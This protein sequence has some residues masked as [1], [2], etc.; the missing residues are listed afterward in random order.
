ML[1]RMD[2]DRHHDPASH[3]NLTVIEGGAIPMGDGFEKRQQ[4]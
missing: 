1:E 4:L 3:D 2:A